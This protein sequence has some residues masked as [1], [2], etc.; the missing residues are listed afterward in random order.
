LEAGEREWLEKGYRPEKGAG[1]GQWLEKGR[2]QRR[3]GSGE[4]QS[5]EKGRGWKKV[6]TYR[7]YQKFSQTPRGLQK[8]E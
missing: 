2:R 5:P 6:V 8:E 1:E 7:E 3:V 4:K